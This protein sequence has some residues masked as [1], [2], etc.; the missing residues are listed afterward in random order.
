M[1]HPHAPSTQNGRDSM[2]RGGRGKGKKGRGGNNG[3]NGN[4]GNIDRAPSYGDNYSNY[5]PHIALDVNAANTSSPWGMHYGG[6][7]VPEANMAIASGPW[8]PPDGHFDHAAAMMQPQIS[9]SGYAMPLRVAGFDTLVHA[10]PIATPA[11]IID[12]PAHEDM[13]SKT[14]SQFETQRDTSTKDAHLAGTPQ[15]VSTKT[16]E[17]ADNA[18]C[19]VATPIAS[20]QASSPM[21]ITTSTQKKHG[22]VDVTPLP[23]N[24]ER[25]FVSNEGHT[26]PLDT[27]HKNPNDT[28]HALDHE[29]LMQLQVFNITLAAMGKQN[30]SRAKTTYATEEASHQK[31]RGILL[32]LIQTARESELSHEKNISRLMDRYH[33][34]MKEACKLTDADAKSAAQLQAIRHSEAFR[35][36]SYLATEDRRRIE[37]FRN[38]LHDLDNARIVSTFAYADAVHEVVTRALGD[39]AGVVVPTKSNTVALKDV[40]LSDTSHSMSITKQSNKIVPP[41]KRAHQPLFERQMKSEHQSIDEVLDLMKS[42]AE[43]AGFKKWEGTVAGSDKIESNAREKGNTESSETHAKSAYAKVV[44]A[45][46]TIE[47]TPSDKKDSVVEPATANNEE[48]SDVQ[49]KE[50]IK[51]KVKSKVGIEMEDTSAGKNTDTTAPVQPPKRKKAWSRNKKK[52]SDAPT[53]MAEGR[54]GG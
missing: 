17:V 8:I 9:S 49:V 42:T 34:N 24:I 31:R 52:G 18:E 28:A 35:E 41:P 3:N 10:P 11:T 32:S 53:V 7:P 16:S 30:L 26:L 12:I 15:D 4:N 6:Y 54:K 1:Q 50:N 43:T 29:A 25:F 27:F 23:P 39:R 47:S 37:R 19:E 46:I 5:G 14:H 40:E 44:T 20:T 45:P 33:H 2:G 21:R 48:Y 38:D 22:S 13:A 36:E 51:D